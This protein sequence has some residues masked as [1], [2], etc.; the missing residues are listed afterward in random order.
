MAE[1]DEQ[2]APMRRSHSNSSTHK[3]LVELQSDRKRNQNDAQILANRI[4]LLR[5]EEEKTRKKIEQTKK[6]ALEIVLLRQDVVE[7]RKQREEVRLR[8]QEE[9]EE[10]AAKARECKER[11]R[12]KIQEMRELLLRQK[13]HE[14]LEIKKQTH[15]IQEVVQSHRQ[16]QQEKNKMKREA[17]RQ[18]EEQVLALRKELKDKRLQE[19][20][21]N[22]EER[23][24]DEE[25]KNGTLVKKIEQLEKEEKELLSKLTNTQ[26]VHQMAYNE[27][28]LAL[29]M[30]PNEFLSKY[31]DEYSGAL[32]SRSNRGSHH[33]M[34]SSLHVLISPTMRKGHM[35]TKT[36]AEGLSPQK[37]E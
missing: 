34:T 4:S 8:L 32:K 14:M 5:L 12:K 29:S 16:Q 26:S 35:R 20:K 22:Y 27:L 3:T 17:V 21:S 19:G 18:S 30:P 10:I 15:D 11:D 28:R 31:K 2:N 13:R 37:E 9:R 24:K 25:G 36:N 1:V 6:K 7:Q 33:Q 23:Q